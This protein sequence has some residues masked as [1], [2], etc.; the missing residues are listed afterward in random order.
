MSTFLISKNNLA[1]LTDVVKAR[2]NLGI[3]TLASQNS[4]NVNITGGSIAVS[5][6]ILHH[7]DAQENSL[8]ISEDNKGTLGFYKPNF[9]PWM[10]NPQD[11]V[12]IGTF[13]N[14]LGFVRHN[15]LPP[16]VM[17]GDYNDLKNIPEDITELYNKS[18]FCLVNNNLSDLED[19][20][21]VKKNLG[22][23]QFASFDRTDE[24][25]ISNLHVTSNFSFMPDTSDMSVWGNKYLQLSHTTEDDGSIKTKWVDLPKAGENAYGLLQ[26]SDDFNSRDPYTAPSSKALY[27]AFQELDKKIFDSSGSH[28]FMTTLINDY[29]LLIKGNN[30]SEFSCNISQVKSN[31]NLGNL[32]EQD[33]NDVTIASLT[34][35]DNFFYGSGFPVEGN[36]LKCKSI[37]G[38]AI[39]SKLPYAYEH[40]SGV[41]YITNDMNTPTNP[42][43]AQYTV[44]NVFALSNFY[45]DISTEIQNISDKV[46][47][48]VTDLTD[49][50][51]FCM[52]DDGFQYI[53]AKKAKINLKLAEV[54]SSGSYIDLIDQPTTLT[55]FTNDKF[56]TINNNLS[57]LHSK[58]IARIN[59]G[60][61]TMSEQN[62]ANV[63]IIGGDASFDTL[64]ITE[65]FVFDNNIP[66]SSIDTENQMYY[67]T[68]VNTAGKVGWRKMTQ[69][70]EKLHGV[71]QLTHN[72][73][74]ITSINKVAS[75]TAVFKVYN[76]LSLRIRMINERIFRI[77]ISS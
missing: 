29:G 63:D 50:K 42:S 1:E 18:K 17:S 8:V 38:E 14:N 16:V 21:I 27:D 7:A 31:L 58:D 74:D 65:N 39:W 60:L 5:S 9:K 35:T 52:V 75:A 46:P 53:D 51:K 15:E 57:D 49:W 23:G 72:I 11:I 59:L 22:L 32:S 56:L 28:D 30:L 66:D 6:L 41:V 73:D 3:G 4:D 45:S 62:N 77:K 76:D 24:V 61:G 40:A 26:I 48:K 55:S 37:T 34:V 47:T 70:T 36:F 68:A 44:P 20:D 67:M 10:E 12:D 64:H 43:K 33:S 54:A 69:A 13:S 2:N 25:T 71:V 19:F